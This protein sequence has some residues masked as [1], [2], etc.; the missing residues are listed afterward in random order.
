MYVLV[1]G[2]AARH[3]DPGL[4]AGDAALPGGTF[5]ITIKGNPLR[6]KKKTPHPHKKANNPS[7]AALLMQD[8]RGLIKTGNR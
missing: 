8:K 5:G 2:T 7:M 3:A 4:D 6:E 1:F